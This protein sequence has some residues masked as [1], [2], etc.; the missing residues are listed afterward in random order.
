MTR[1]G[2]N[3]GSLRPGSLW[4]PFPPH[5]GRSLGQGCGRRRGLGVG[6]GRVRSSPS[7]AQGVRGGVSYLGRGKR[8]DSGGGFRSSSGPGPAGVNPQQAGLPP[9]AHP[10]PT[11][12]AGPSAASRAGRPSSPLGYRPRL[13]AAAAAAA[14]TAAAGGPQPLL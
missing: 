13:L 1:S 8:S 14:V 2:T 7:C 10:P 9:P 12:A 11:T 4:Y 6:E 5:L 3:P